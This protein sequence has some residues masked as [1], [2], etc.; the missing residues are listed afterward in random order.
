[1]KPCGKSEGKRHF[2]NGREVRNCFEKAI[3]SQSLRVSALKD[4]TLEQLSTLIMR[5]VGNSL[6]NPNDLT[7]DFLAGLM[8][9]GCCR[10][11]C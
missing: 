10:H 9:H 3:V 11:L 5:D 2:G 1:M 6:K 7:E 8:T 4:P